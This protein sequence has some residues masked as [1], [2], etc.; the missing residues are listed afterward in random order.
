MPF[1]PWSLTQLWCLP[2]LFI[3]LFH[4][5][6]QECGR[7][8]STIEILCNVGGLPI[9][10]LPSPKDLQTVVVVFFQNHIIA[11][12]AV[13][14]WW[15]WSSFSRNFCCWQNLWLQRKKVLWYFCYFI[16]QWLQ[17]WLLNLS[18]HYPTWLRYFESGSRIGFR[19][20]GLV[21]YCLINVWPCLQNCDKH[22]HKVDELVTL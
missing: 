16:F 20:L 12:L 1:Q 3:T 17:I 6:Y 13:F 7:R 8:K 14:L 5:P 11:W 19:C 15:Q 9:G 10:F 4:D 18:L 22:E 2:F 21:A